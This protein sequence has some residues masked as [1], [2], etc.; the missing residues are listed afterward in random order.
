V[1]GLACHDLTTC[2]AKRN[3]LSTPLEKSNIITGVFKDVEREGVVWSR[4]RILQNPMLSVE[5][6]FP[7]IPT[8]T[9]FPGC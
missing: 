3:S 7:A 4:R 6:W 9:L 8:L 2:D 1:G 5:Y